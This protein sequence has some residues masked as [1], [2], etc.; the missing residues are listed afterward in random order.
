MKVIHNFLYI[1]GDDI[2]E[3]DF[4]LWFNVHTNHLRHYKSLYNKSILMRKTKA[5]FHNPF[6]ND[7]LKRKVCV[8]FFVKKKN[9][10]ISP[11]KPIFANN[12]D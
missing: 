11:L 12:F 1:D 6:A 2:D 8:F 9:P 3:Y 4:H 5:S 10:L 7:L